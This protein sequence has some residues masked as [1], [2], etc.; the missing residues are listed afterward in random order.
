MKKFNEYGDKLVSFDVA[1][2]AKLIGY[3]YYQPECFSVYPKKNYKNIEEIHK[4]ANI[5]VDEWSGSIGDDF[6]FLCYRPTQSTLQKWIR[7]KHSIQVWVKP[8]PNEKKWSVYVDVW[9]SH[10]LTDYEIDDTYE[11]ALEEGLLFACKYI[12]EEKV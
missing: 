1:L 4:E 7:E 9:G 12:K 8:V 3:E 5:I 10:I 11:S 6:L 2:L